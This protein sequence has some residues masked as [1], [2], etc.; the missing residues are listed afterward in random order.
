MSSYYNISGAQGETLLLNLTCRDSSSNY[1][2]LS[3][4]SVSGYVKEKYSSTGKLFD[5]N[6]SVVSA[7]SGMISLSGA[8]SDLENTPVGVYVYGVEAQL[9]DYVFR[10]INGY[11]YLFPDAINL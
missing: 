9:N 6:V 8:A 1:I 10:P 11:F 3:G 5:L 7:V 2:N 4:Y